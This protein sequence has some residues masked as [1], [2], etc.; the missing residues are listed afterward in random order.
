MA[1]LFLS[2]LPAALIVAA[3][4]DVYEYKIPNW[5]SFVLLVAYPFA[6]LSTGAPM[7]LFG[8]GLMAGAIVL[9]VCFCLFAWNVLGG[10]DAKLLATAAPWFAMSESLLIFL[11]ATG[12]VGGLLAMGILVFRQFPIFPVY[13]RYDWL[14]ELHQ[15]E[16]GIPYAVAIAA[17]GI[18]AFPQSQLYLLA[19]GG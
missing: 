10:G 2:I 15:S 12:F 11:L 9:V 1:F 13:A 18:A 19:M 5:L 17:G 4:N 14:M 7:A 3:I 16:K 8:S 6:I